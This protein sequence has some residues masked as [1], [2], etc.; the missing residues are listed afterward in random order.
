MSRFAKR[1]VATK[2]GF[3]E[4]THL[5]EQP[6]GSI[7][8]SILKQ[9]RKSGV[10]NLSQRGLTTVP[11]AVWKIQEMVPEEAKSVSMDNAD[12][13]W[14]DTVDLTKLILASNHLSSLGEG[15]SNL[16]ALTVLDIHDNQL[17]SLPAGIK[18]LENLQK[19]DISRNQLKEI[20]IQIGFLSN[21]TSLHLENNQLLEICA[22]ICSLRKLEFLD[23]SNNQI[24]SLPNSI[25]LMSQLRHLNVANN[26]LT[27]L[28]PDIG[29]LTAL[30]MFDATHNQLQSLPDEFGNLLHLEQLFL[31]HN[32]LQYL[33]VLH[34][35][36]NLKEILVGNNSIRGLTEEHLHHLTSLT[37]LDLRDNKLVK[38]PDEITL[39]EKLERLD[40]TNNDI[41]VL[42]YKMGC[43]TA[44]KAIILD[45]NPMRSIRR[46][47][48]MRGTAELKKY[49]LSRLKDEEN[50]GPDS[51]VSAS[52]VPMPGVADDVISQ[53]DLHQMKS[54]DFSNKKVASVPE[55][56]IKVAVEAGIRVINLS[57]NLLPDLP[58]GLLALAPTLT[59]INLGFNKI[60]QLSPSTERFTKLFMLDLRNNQLSSLPPQLASLKCLR[61]LILSNNRFLEIPAVVYE[62]SKLEILFVS[63]NKITELDHV[64]FS[65]LTKLGT[66]DLQ[67]ND[68]T[69]VP[70]QL[71][72]CTWLK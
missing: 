58:S 29:D 72:N 45:G 39:L 53:H 65:K 71:G 31:R 27:H 9:A 56:I 59:E 1:Q 24:H 67:N 48:V 26:K 20:P 38:L 66:L 47:I 14:W 61:E 18:H 37:S 16:Q 22:D 13:K 41:S 63:D 52:A 7:H 3:S 55:D 10:L 32:Q 44:L 2:G 4:S 62:L 21:L 51:Q 70:P 64:G 50:E 60:S 12:D 49:L 54:L 5:T 42:P 30:R 11:D 69:Q 25:R 8:P 35:C 28:P 68:I 17:T 19:L 36:T 33:P 46:D 34:H 57:K 43:M 6:L 23:V 15:L 40:L